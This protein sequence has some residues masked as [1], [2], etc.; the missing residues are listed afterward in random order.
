VFVR[1]AREHFHLRAEVTALAA[2]F[3]TRS[4]SW[5]PPP[6]QKTP[7][8]AYKAPPANA[9]RKGNENDQAIKRAP[10]TEAA[11]R[12]GR[13]RS[14][15]ARPNSHA[16]SSGQCH[17]RQAIPTFKPRNRPIAIHLS[18]SVHFFPGETLDRNHAETNGHSFTELLPAS[19]KG[20]YRLLD[21]VRNSGVASPRNRER[22]G[23]YHG[24]SLARVR[25][26]TG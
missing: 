24:A 2:I 7:R 20:N 15:E 18:P 11:P 17:N 9:V 16:V 23:G 4:T 10:A 14:F 26:S 3:R 22:A 13:S 5:P 12:T 8:P 25:F 21:S 1:P 6:S 19:F